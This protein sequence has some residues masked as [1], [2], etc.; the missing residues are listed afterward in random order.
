M[1]EC[2]NCLFWK[3]EWWDDKPLSIGECTLA[4]T[5]SCIDEQESPQFFA[6]GQT[7]AGMLYCES[8]HYCNEYKSKVENTDVR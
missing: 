3:R 8:D 2:R 5:G 7:D 4:A 6:V 1:K